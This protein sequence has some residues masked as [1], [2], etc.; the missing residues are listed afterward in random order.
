MRYINDGLY[1]PRDEGPEEEVMFMVQDKNV[2]CNQK[3]ST[4]ISSH[5]HSQVNQGI[6]A[7]VALVIFG[8]K[9]SCFNKSQYSFDS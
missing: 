2:D 6:W 4:D 1:L 8:K 5:F 3:L 7:F 9:L